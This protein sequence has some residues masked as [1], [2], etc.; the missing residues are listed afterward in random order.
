MSINFYFLAESLCRVVAIFHNENSPEIRAQSRDLMLMYLAYKTLVFKCEFR[1]ESSI[2]Q[3]VYF[4]KIRYFM[5][6]TCLFCR[7]RPMALQIRYKLT[8]SSYL[9][10]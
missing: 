6:T 8:P 3:S 5:S 1:S 7:S 4:H 9:S 10:Y 2:K